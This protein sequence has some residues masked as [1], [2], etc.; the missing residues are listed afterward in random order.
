MDSILSVCDSDAH[1][2][3]IITGDDFISD[4]KKKQALKSQYP[5]LCVDMESTA[6]AH[7]AFIHEVPF[8]V[9]RCISDLADENATE[10]YENF[11]RLAA[12]K[13]SS[14]VLKVLETLQ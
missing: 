1:I 4:P 7:A 8:S 10:D 13:A 6:V 5:A 3:L 14:I 2:G 9:I 11:E 12:Q